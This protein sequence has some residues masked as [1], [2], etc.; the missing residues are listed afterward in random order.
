[1]NVRQ[2]RT[3]VTRYAQ[4]IAAMDGSTV[5]VEVGSLL[6][7]MAPAVMVSIYSVNRGGYIERQLHILRIKLR[8][9]SLHRLQILM[10]VR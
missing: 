5:L 7:K 1:M 3:T 4:L 2:K 10:S 8:E 9:E 6:E